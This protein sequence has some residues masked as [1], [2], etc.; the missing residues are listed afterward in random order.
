[1][2][3]PITPKEIEVVIKSVQPK[4]TEFYHN[5]QEELILILFKLFHTIETEGTLPN[6]FDEATVTLLPKPYKGATKR[7]TDQSPF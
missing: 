7:I 4:S 5:F 6:Y 2:N 3:R 1:M